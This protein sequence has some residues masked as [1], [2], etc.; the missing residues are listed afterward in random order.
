MNGIDSRY[1]VTY[2]SRTNTTV[3]LTIILVT[4][5]VV[6]FIVIIVLLLR[7]STTSSICT[8]A[9]SPPTTVTSVYVSPTQFNVTWAPVQN[10]KTY[11]V[12][13][14]TTN[15]FSPGQAILTKTSTAP[16]AAIT[17]LTTNTTYYILIVSTN[18]C[19]TS[20]PSEQL[21]F[22]FVNP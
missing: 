15:G 20:V 6:I 9:P 10:A 18:T 4:I 3:A 5:V 19:G 12:Y 1:F 8:A 13:I 11:T 17:N 16:P 7:R 21:T 14:G 22:Q 2:P